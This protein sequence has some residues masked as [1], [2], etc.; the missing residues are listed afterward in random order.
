M[1]ISCLQ[2]GKELCRLSGGTLTQLKMQ[3]IL[4]YAHMIH[5]GRTSEPLIKNDFLAWKHGPVAL[6]LYDYVK[7]HEADD[8][9]LDAFAIISDLDKGAEEFKSLDEAYGKL[10][11]L[12]ASQLVAAS[13]SR[14][15]AWDKTT[16]MGKVEM[17]NDLIKEEYDVCHIIR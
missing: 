15:G 16:R 7:E 10:R 3:K 14:G 17:R 13:H 11:E 12:T 8:I 1:A 6:G 5:L 2:A 9:P 4:Y